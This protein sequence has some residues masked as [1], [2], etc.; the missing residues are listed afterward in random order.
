MIRL[1][2]AP[3]IEFAKLATVGYEAGGGLCHEAVFALAIASYQVRIAL[4]LKGLIYEYV[5]LDL[6]KSRSD[7]H[8]PEHM[9]VNPNGM[10]AF[11]RIAK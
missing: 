11:R 8:R 1:E 9:R 3:L 4:N 10:S 5:P 2:P 7:Q 6:D